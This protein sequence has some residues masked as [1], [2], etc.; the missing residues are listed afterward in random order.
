VELRDLLQG[1]KVSQRMGPDEDVESMS[2][3]M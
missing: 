3:Y 2:L 1:T